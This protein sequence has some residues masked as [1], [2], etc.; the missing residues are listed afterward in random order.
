MI[1]GSIINKGSSYGVNVVGHGNVVVQPTLA[2]PATGDL[3]NPNATTAAVDPWRF[4]LRE[5]STGRSAKVTKGDAQLEIHPPQNGGQRMEW[6]V[7]PKVP[8]EC[9]LLELDW[10]F[11][12]QFN[13]RD[14][15]RAT[16]CESLLTKLGEEMFDSIFADAEAKRYVREALSSG[17]ET[18]WSIQ[19]ST[20]F[21]R[22][23]WE[24]LRHS[25]GD[26]SRD[27]ATQAAFSRRITD[28]P[29]FRALVPSSSK[30]SV[31]WFAARVN[32]DDIPADAVAKSI[33]L[34]IGKA[35]DFDL[36]TD[37]RYETLARRLCDNR[38]RPCYHVLHLDMHGIVA[39]GQDLRTRA[40]NQP[41]RW[42]VDDRHERGDVPDTES[43]QA[44]LLFAD[45]GPKQT[46]RTDP[47]SAVELANAISESQIPIVV[48]NACHSATVPELS[49]EAAS[50]P[51]LGKR[52]RPSTQSALVAQLV[53]AGGFSAVGF[54]NS[55]HLIAARSFFQ[56]FYKTLVQSPD[57]GNLD[58]AIID[59]RRAL[60]AKR[61]RGPVQLVDW[62]L[63]VWYASRDVVLPVGMR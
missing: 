27:I 19:G 37:G 61:T 38:R 60:R 63:P 57:S 16:T 5:L 21:H 24:L 31:L 39:S 62:C 14:P 45:A 18:V 50:E 4:V 55:L 35:V 56:A 2:P 1:H 23:P 7:Q 54:S 33:Q 52:A 8:S 32:Q 28:P 12:G 43:E 9:Q 13:D 29:A 30:L 11:H 48:L 49:P 44:W 3:Q 46:I 26:F 15:K 47:A 40:A 58:R 53:K 20:Q 22:F 51:A 34:E 10:Y 41:G 17:Q 25:M 42:I 36:V 59:G 6:T